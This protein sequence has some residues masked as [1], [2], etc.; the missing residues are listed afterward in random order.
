MVVISVLNTI[1]AN[2]LIVMFKQAAQENQVCTIGGQQTMLSMS[3]EPGRVQALKHGVCVL[4]FVGTFS[5]CP[6][7][8]AIRGE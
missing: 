4:S 2:Q 8:Q 7:Y 3:M 1:I 6:S 5:R